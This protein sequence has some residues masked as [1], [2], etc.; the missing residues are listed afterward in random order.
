MYRIDNQ[1]EKILNIKKQGE[2]LSILISEMGLTQYQFADLVGVTEGYVS[3]IIKG[4]RHISDGLMFKILDKCKVS[5]EWL[6][7]GKGGM[8]KE[9][10]QKQNLRQEREDSYFSSSDPSQYNQP[11]VEDLKAIIEE[12]NKR[13]ELLEEIK[14][15][16]AE[17]I[18]ELEE[19]L[20]N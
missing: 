16:D 7:N 15:R 12:K 9:E 5:Q 11:K 10:G 17:K 18:K 3:H 20:K 1:E 4:K 6:R 14:K 2:R 8:F 19:K 13:I